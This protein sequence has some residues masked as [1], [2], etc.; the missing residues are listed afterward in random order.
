MF[1]MYKYQSTVEIQTL[2]MSNVSGLGPLEE[3]ETMKGAL[4]SFT[5]SLLKIVAVGTLSIG[6]T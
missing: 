5:A 4:L 6:I 2:R 1:T 3:N